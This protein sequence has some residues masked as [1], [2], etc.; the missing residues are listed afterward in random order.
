MTTSTT[1][2]RLTRSRFN[3]R[4]GSVFGAWFLPTA[5]A[6]VIFIVLCVVQPGVGSYTGVS[7]TL[8]PLLPLVLAALAQMFVIAGGDIDLGIGSFVSLVNVI[9][10]VTLEK[11][12]LL[13]TLFRWSAWS[14]PTH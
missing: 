11:N 4:L 3:L 10:A 7:L 14:S 13:G 9:F 1:G 8:G 5:A 6:I 2:V 12:V